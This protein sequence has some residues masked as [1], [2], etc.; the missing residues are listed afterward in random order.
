MVQLGAKDAFSSIPLGE[1]KPSRV[2][3]R[4]QKGERGNM[5]TKIKKWG[6]GW[7]RRKE[8]KKEKKR[9]RKRICL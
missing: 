7:E 2:Q 6:R 5:I 9:E 3:E 8:G 4:T 1:D